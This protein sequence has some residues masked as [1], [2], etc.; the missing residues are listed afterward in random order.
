MH[1]RLRITRWG[2]GLVS[3]IRRT[4][5]HGLNGLCM[6]GR[7]HGIRGWWFLGGSITLCRKYILYV[8]GMVDLE[9]LKLLLN[10][11]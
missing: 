6:G 2:R 5:G 3:G 9:L 1:N 11:L 10:F 4:T 7:H 8:L